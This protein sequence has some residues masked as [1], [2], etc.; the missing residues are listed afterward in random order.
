M[1][2]I[3][4]RIGCR[5]I[6]NLACKIAAPSAVASTRFSSSTPAAP[7]A[8]EDKPTFRK[9]NEAARIDLSNFGRYVAECLP[10][11]VQK[12]QLTAGDELEVLI[13]PEGVVPVLQFLKDNHL[14]QF[15]N[16][17]DI[18]GMD[19]PSRQYRFEVIYNLLS[20]RFN[21]R[22]RV[23]TYTDELTPLDSCNEVF[24]AAN[25]YE[26]EIWDMYGVFFA[27]HP[28]LRRILTDYGFEGHPQRRDFPLSGYVELRYDDEKKRVVCEPLELA[29]EFR[30]FDLSAP[31]EQFPN[32]RNA[33]PP[34]ET[35]ETK[36]ETSKK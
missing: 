28:D 19:V 17:V 32:F 8:V 31:W 23:K 16:L 9:P 27:N 34:A 33:N 2:A 3:I 29:Q 15:S 10:K 20:L 30:K 25:W 35:V 12:V 36:Q 7:P 24:K 26:R 4:R 11:Y 6:G 1:A 18:A 13:A 14:A 21:S 22:I 5:A